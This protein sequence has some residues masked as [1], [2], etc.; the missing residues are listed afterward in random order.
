MQAQPF[1]SGRGPCQ[2]AAQGRAWGSHRLLFFCMALDWLCC[3]AA[4]S[5]CTGQ[6]QLP[7]GAPG[8]RRNLLMALGQIQGLMPVRANQRWPTLRAAKGL[9]QRCPKGVGQYAAIF[10][11]CITQLSP[12][13]P[14]STWRILCAFQGVPANPILL[15]KRPQ[16]PGNHHFHFRTTVAVII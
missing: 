10:M 7:P 15:C 6:C 13:I 2:P 5:P 16:Q 14:F 3:C 11:T 9:I 1:D 12:T 8:H 4:T